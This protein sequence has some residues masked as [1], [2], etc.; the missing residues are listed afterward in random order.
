MKKLLLIAVMAF[1]GI[2]AMAQSRPDSYN[3]KRGLEA[4]GDQKN[5]EAIEW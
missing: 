2:G 3:Y 4:V 5:D 1:F